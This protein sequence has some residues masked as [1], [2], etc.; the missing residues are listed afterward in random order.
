MMRVSI[1]AVVLFAVVL[2]ATP[3]M[4]A[5][6]QSVQ[7]MWGDNAQPQQ[8]RQG[9][10]FRAVCYNTT[11]PFCGGNA[12]SVCYRTLESARDAAREHNEDTGHNAVAGCAPRDM[13][14]CGF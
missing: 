1:F 6:T 3:V 4:L 12:A 11:H 7:A 14:R 8:C 5:G 13:P 2:F 10:C 9:F